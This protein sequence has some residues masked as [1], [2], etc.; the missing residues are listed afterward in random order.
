M[1]AVGAE[2]L[3]V[4]RGSSIMAKRAGIG[5][6][7]VRRRAEGPGEGRGFGPVQPAY[8]PGGRAKRGQAGE[9]P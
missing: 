5:R 9:R 1:R 8:L 7:P 2:G 4:R 6:P 3:G